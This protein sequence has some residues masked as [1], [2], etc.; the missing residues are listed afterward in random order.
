[1]AS[2]KEWHWKTTGMISVGGSRTDL[3]PVEFTKAM[4]LAAITKDY[5][6]VHTKAE[7]TYLALHDINHSPLQLP[8]TLRPTPDGFVSDTLIFVYK[9][10]DV[11]VVRE[12]TITSVLRVKPWMGRKMHCAGPSPLWLPDAVEVPPGA[13]AIRG[14]LRVLAEPITVNLRLIGT[15]VVGFC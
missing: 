12:V 8:V 13:E 3:D 9:I 1:M 11:E 7:K 5:S 10:P 14:R 4:A 2:Q 6:F 15:T